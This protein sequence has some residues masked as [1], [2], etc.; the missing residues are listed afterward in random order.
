LVVGFMVS[1]LAVRLAC[2]AA[3]TAL[4]FSLVAIL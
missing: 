4:S 3:S 2:V 1:L